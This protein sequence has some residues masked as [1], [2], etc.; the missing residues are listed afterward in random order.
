MQDS[1]HKRAEELL[2]E[3]ENG[4]RVDMK[5]VLNSQYLGKVYFGTPTSQPATVVFDTGSNWLTV[6]SNLCQGCS[7]QA[8]N[9]AHSDTAVK[10]Q[11]EALDQK[12]GSA[13]L[14]GYI[15][16]DTVCLSPLDET[17]SLE[18]CVEQ[19]PFMA[20]KSE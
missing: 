8:Y 11:D 12:Y 20:I 17:K 4:H 18:S 10:V 7:S 5:N 14:S 15:W 13:D 1:I 16:N 2:L 6:T 3:K 9:T 19:F